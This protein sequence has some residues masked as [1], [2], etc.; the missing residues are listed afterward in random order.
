MSVI[1]A[2][3]YLRYFPAIIYAAFS[4]V[5]Y[6]IF[7]I[8]TGAGEKIMTFCPSHHVVQ[9]LQQ[10]AQPRAACEVVVREMLESS[11][12]WF[13]VGLIALDM[14]VSVARDGWSTTYVC[15]CTHTIAMLSY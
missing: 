5:Q 9:L 15:T 7:S 13:E 14:K 2:I 8:A 6:S 3:I 1:V 10:G 12:D 11:A 4:V